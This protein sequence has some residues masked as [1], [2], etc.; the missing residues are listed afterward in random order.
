[1]KNSCTPGPVCE[2]QIFFFSKHT[3]IFVFLSHGLRTWEGG[4]E[5]SQRY[6]ATHHGL[7]VAVQ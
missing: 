3:L 2:R 7:Y 1:M 5:T 6:F 4:F